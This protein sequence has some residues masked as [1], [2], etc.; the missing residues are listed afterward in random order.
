MPRNGK[1]PSIPNN[2]GWRNVVA[3]SI[4]IEYQEV[5]KIGRNS[6]R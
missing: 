3:F 1:S 5:S 2:G 4:T 6:R